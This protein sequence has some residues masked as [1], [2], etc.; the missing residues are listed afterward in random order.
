MRLVTT[1]TMPQREQTWKSAVRV[2]KAYVDT[3]AGSLIDTCK[4]RRGFEVQMPPCLV[5][6][7]QPQARAWISTGSGS[8]A[9][10]KE[11]LPQWHLPW[12]SMV[13]SRTA[14]PDYR[15]GSSAAAAALAPSA[16]RGPRD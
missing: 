6:N 13:R 1:G 12:I 3:S 7:E 16:R 2:P 4:A 5:Q 15:P 9:S 10:A 8:Q 14:A 11:M